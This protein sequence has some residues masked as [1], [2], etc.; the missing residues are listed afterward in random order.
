MITD[1]QHRLFIL[2]LPFLTRNINPYKIYIKILFKGMLCAVCIF[3][4][5]PIFLSV[6]LG[7]YNDLLIKQKDISFYHPIIK[8]NIDFIV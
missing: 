1:R 5:H 3:A 8:I 7:Y 4:G 6:I 2:A